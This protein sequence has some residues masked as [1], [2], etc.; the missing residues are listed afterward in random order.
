MKFLLSLTFLFLAALVVN[1]KSSDSSFVEL[2]SLPAEDGPGNECFE[3]LKNHPR[4]NL[5]SKCT[6]FV[7]DKWRRLHEEND[8]VGRCC[9]LYELVNCA[10]AE[11]SAT[12]NADQLRAVNSYHAKTVNSL[13]GGECSSVPLDQLGQLCKL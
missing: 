11:A 2:P 3:I 4:E 1:C 13:E 6:S 12:C 8:L 5:L 9:A 10:Q 7:T